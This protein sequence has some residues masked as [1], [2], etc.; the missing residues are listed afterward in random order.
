[1][2][3]SNFSYSVSVLMSVYKEPESWI[4]ASIESILNQDFTDF[5]FIIINDN[6]ESFPIKLLL[7]KYL[8]LDKRIKVFTNDQ[9]RGLIYCLN[10]GLS[11]SEGKYI[12]RMDA[13]DIS[14]C[15]RLRIQFNF[16]DCPRPLWRLRARLL[17]RLFLQRSGRLI[18]QTHSS[19][20]ANVDK[21]TLHIGAVAFI[22]RFG[23]S[24]NEH[25]HFSSDV[26]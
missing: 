25:V 22:H 14:H 11:K 26:T 8:R 4:S 3:L 10:Y 18:L 16:L 7:D 15:T 9:N 21:A 12:A 24:L 1:M 6:P 2:G 5:E 13:D 20:A 23:S 19:S 17:G